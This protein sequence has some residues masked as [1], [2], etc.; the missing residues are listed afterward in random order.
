[1]VDDITPLAEPAA[2]AVA[3]TEQQLAAKQSP[4]ALYT[5]QWL[6]RGYRRP[7]CSTV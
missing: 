1:M 5:E 2:T 4:V 7:R 3:V 6:V